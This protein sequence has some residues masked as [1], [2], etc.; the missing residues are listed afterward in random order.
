[1]ACCKAC[2]EKDLKIEELKETIKSL[3]AKLN[4]RERNEEEGCFGL[5]TPS[6]K[7]PLKKILD[8]LARNHEVALVLLVLRSLT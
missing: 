3:Q 2:L 6:S 4:Y 1:M 5:S 8:Q 7:V